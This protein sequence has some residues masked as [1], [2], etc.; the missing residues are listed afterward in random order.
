MP[1]EVWRGKLE[2]YVDGELS[3]P[4]TNALGNHM[5]GCTGCAAAALERVQMKRSVAM[6][7]KRYEPSAEFRAKI[8]TT[9]TTMSERRGGWFC[10][11]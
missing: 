5:R 9:L 1:C 11:S 6:A 3:V 8:A 4:E 10:D 7:G 2:A